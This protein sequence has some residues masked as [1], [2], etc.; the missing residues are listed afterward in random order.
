MRS[1][2]NLSVRREKVPS[3]AG[4]NPARAYHFKRRIISYL[5]LSFGPRK[6]MKKPRQTMKSFQRVSLVLRGCDVLG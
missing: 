6:Q 2:L 3:T 5:S 1:S 4:E